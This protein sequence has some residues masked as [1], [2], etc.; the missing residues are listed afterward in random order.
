MTCFSWQ[1]IKARARDA[2]Y[3]RNPLSIRAF[4]NSSSQHLATSM[5]RILFQEKK[6][7]HTSCCEREMMDV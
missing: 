5:R 6:N 2:M 1:Y 3:C 4:D 7:S